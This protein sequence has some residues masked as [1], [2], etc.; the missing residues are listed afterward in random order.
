MKVY[1]KLCMLLLLGGFPWNIV[2]AT[3]YNIAAGPS[4]GFLFD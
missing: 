1:L 3:P 2:Q 4:I